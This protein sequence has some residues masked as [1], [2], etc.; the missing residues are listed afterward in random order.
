MSYYLDGREYRESTG[1][2]EEKQARK[3]LRLRLQEIA[4]DKSGIQP[5]LGPGAS[6]VRINDLL[7][8]LEQDYRVRGKLSPSIMSHLK[9]MRER[10]GSTRATQ[11]DAKE[12][13]AYI[14]EQLEADAAP[15]TINRR[16]QL[17]GQAYNL[18]LLR[19]RLTKKPHIRKLPERNVRQGFFEHDEFAAII[20][21]LPEHLQDYCRFAYLTG[22][23]RGECSSLTWEDVDQRAR[24]IHLRPERSKNGHSRKVALEGE[25][26]EIIQRRWNERATTRKNGSTTMPRYVF[27][28]DGH[29][30]GEFKKSWANAC[31]AAGVGRKLFHDFRRTA[32]RNMVRAGVPE[33]VAMKISGHR[34]RAVFDRYNIT[35][36][37]DL[38]EAMRKTQAYL[39][40]AV[41]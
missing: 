16:T 19:G 9:P 27:H 36:E 31:T 35:D 20:E 4:N 7:D 14:A 6:R 11:L 15:A 28:R 34:T 30:I 23:R 29:P 18:A 39:Q 26:W 10:F 32:V 3:A 40:D 17:L 2:T 1:A 37:R 22:W 33:S 8:E 21:N 24:L 12:I 13:D 25:L 5:F 38:R 41:R